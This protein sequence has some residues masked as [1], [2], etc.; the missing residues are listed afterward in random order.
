MSLKIQDQEFDM[1]QKAGEDILTALS[2]Y[3]KR[4]CAQIG[5]TGDMRTDT[6]IAR[7]L[8]N[9]EA[10]H[11]EVTCVIDSDPENTDG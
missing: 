2:A 4:L 11:Y 7:K 3:H 9:L 1:D 8:I 10:V 5:K 6:E